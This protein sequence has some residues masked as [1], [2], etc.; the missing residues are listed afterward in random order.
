MIWGK[1]SFQGADYAPYQDKV[2][3]LMLANPTLYRQF[4]MVSKK[5][6]EIGEDVCYIGVPN[7][8]LFT[9]FDGFQRVEESEL[10]KV[11]DALLVADGTTEE[12]KSRFRFRGEGK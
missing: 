9:A 4:I 6:G 5:T 1:R 10:P 7:E 8:I 3:K 2:A 12:F 11:I